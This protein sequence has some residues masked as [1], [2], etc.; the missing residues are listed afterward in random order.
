M[1]RQYIELKHNGKQWIRIPIYPI[2]AIKFIIE[3]V[4]WGVFPTLD[5]NMFKTDSILER[6][7]YYDIKSLYKGRIIPQYVIGPFWAD[8]ALPDYKLVI[9]LDGATYHQDKEKDRRRDAFMKKKGW[10]VLRFTYADIK[11]RRAASIQKITEYTRKIDEK[12]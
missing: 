12:R 2:L 6:W 10:K 8:F 9:E 5:L 3:Q 1:R 4:Q 11:K 7:L